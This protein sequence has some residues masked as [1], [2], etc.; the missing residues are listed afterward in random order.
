MQ[1]LAV[2]FSVQNLLPKIQ[3]VFLPFFAQWCS[4]QIIYEIEMCA[5][6]GIFSSP[7]LNTNQ[8]VMISYQYLM[9]EILKK[10]F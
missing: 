3:Q 5:T 10:K 6:Y 1:V 2:F 4:T 9:K 8:I 7:S